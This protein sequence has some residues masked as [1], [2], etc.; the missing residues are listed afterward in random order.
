MA[1]PASMTDQIENVKNY[2]LSY[3]I[4]HPSAI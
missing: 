1:M 3:R 4:L 2:E